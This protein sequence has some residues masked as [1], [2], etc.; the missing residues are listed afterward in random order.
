VLRAV[1]DANVYVSAAIRPEGPPG[2]L[3]EAFVRHSSFELVMSPAIIDEV[4]ET[5]KD[6]KVRRH[7]RAQIDAPTWFETI[8]VL[9]D[10]VPGEHDIFGVCR[11]PDDDK[12]LAAAVEGRATFVVTGD[13]DLLDI[14]EHA[15]IQVVTPRQFLDALEVRRAVNNQ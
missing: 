13:S 9:A 8:A 1:L 5:V 7:F 2:Q 12:Y 6:P 4:I 3:L 10:V 14:R 11:D 15:G